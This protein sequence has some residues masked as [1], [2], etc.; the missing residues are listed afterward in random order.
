MPIDPT[1][2]FILTA[3]AKQGVKSFE[4]LSIAE[5]RGIIDT[6]PQLQNAPEPVEHVE[7]LALDG[8]PLRVYRPA[9]ANGSAILYTHGGGWIGGHL[10]VC[11]EPVRA[12]ANETGAVVVATTY[13]LA[14]EARFPAQPD[15]VFAALKWLHANAARLG[16]DPRRVALVGD[17]AG[18]NLMAVTAI[19]ARDAGLPVAAQV[20]VYPVIDRRCEGASKT[21]C[22]EG[23]L[24]SRAAVDWFW[25]HYLAR[26]EDIAS[27]LASPLNAADLSGLPPALV[28]TAEYDPSR[29]EAIEYCNALAAAGNDARH[30]PLPGLIHGAFWMSGAIPRASEVL[31]AIGEFLDEQLGAR[32]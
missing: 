26:P 28:L 6:F 14:P 10:D 24:I 23:Y 25:D 2:Q 20:L 22:A 11:D 30:V 15:D 18:G 29:D 31:A 1:A 17:S 7:E 4:Q 19:R 9:G 3:L 12:I 27:P 32:A 5:A 13:R 21:E 8:V 16:V